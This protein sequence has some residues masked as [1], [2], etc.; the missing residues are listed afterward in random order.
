MMERPSRRA[1]TRPALART[2][3]CA[4]MVL[5]AV[6]S[7]L[8]ISPAAM[9]SG[10]VFTSRRKIAS[11]PSWARAEREVMAAVISILHVLLKYRAESNDAFAADAW[12][13]SFGFRFSEVRIARYSGKGLTSTFRRSARMI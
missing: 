11:R 8:A 4:D 12:D 2:R 5:A 3:S 13:Q 9:P 1:W 10:P 7:F 6:S